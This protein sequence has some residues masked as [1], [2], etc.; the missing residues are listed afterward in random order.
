MKNDEFKKTVNGMVII[1]VENKLEKKFLG[2][3]VI[4]VVKSLF[5]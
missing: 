4:D 5:L 1:K 3:D 2:R